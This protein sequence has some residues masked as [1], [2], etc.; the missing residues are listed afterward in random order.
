MNLENLKIFLSSR[1]AQRRVLMKNFMKMIQFVLLISLETV[2]S[3]ISGIIRRFT[4]NSCIDKIYSVSVVVG[5][6]KCNANCRHCGGRVLRKDATDGQCGTIRGLKSALALCH[7]Y[8]GWAVSFTGS[9]EPLLS[10]EAI[11]ATLTEINKL[12]DKGIVFPFLN[13]FTNG[14]ELVNNPR[15]REYYLPLWKSLGLTAIAISIH[16]TDYAKNRQAY[17]VATGFNFPR[18]EEMIRVVKEADLVP[19]VTLLLNKGYCDNPAD[20]RRNLDALKALGVNMVTSWP[21]CEP[22][23]ERNKFSPSRW[24]LFKIRFFL[25]SN[26][27][28]IFNQI[29]GGGVYNYRGLSA[30]LTTYVSE[31]KPTNNFIRQLVLFQDGTVA[32]S[33]FQEGAFCL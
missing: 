28:R 17:N 24:N 26:C 19:R 8:G 23:G 5:S 29:W 22:N 20:Y 16:D 11:T 18:L 2:V 12:E 10:P 6:N 1:L 30:R 31:H 4:P 13:L 3:R 32:Y 27:E 15:M 14:I 21:L 33:W 9:G 7:K 25:W